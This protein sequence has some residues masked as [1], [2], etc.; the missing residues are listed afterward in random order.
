MGIT[1]LE[2]R[3]DRDD[4]IQVIR[5]VKGFDLMNIEDFLSWTMVVDVHWEAT[6]EVEGEEKQITTKEVFFQSACDQFM[7]QASGRRWWRSFCQ[8]F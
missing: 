1:S 6:S 5:I 4:L 8:L 3:R 7:E 2:K